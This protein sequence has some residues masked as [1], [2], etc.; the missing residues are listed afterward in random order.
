MRNSTETKEAQIFWNK[1]YFLHLH[2]SA[3]LCNT[4]FLLQGYYFKRQMFLATSEKHAFFFGFALPRTCSKSLVM[5]G[6]GF[7]LE[8][9]PTAVLVWCFRRHRDNF[10]FTNSRAPTVIC[11][12]SECE[13]HYIEVCRL[14]SK[15]FTC[16]WYSRTGISSSSVGP[17]W[18]RAAE[19]RMAI[20]KASFK[21]V[22]ENPMIIILP[23]DKVPRAALKRSLTSWINR[24]YRMNA[25]ANISFYP[26]KDATW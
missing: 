13:F 20:V 15:V 26:Q 8:W 21:L 5:P 14:N 17:N 6:E 23:L 19:K 3:C 18:W 7:Q 12:S 1:C 4:V 9:T 25:E 11:G 24:R 10:N 2:T 22:V 16:V